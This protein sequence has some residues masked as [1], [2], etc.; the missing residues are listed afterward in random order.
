MAGRIRLANE[1]RAR[2]RVLRGRTVV[3]FYAEADINVSL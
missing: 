1:G 2:G 3:T